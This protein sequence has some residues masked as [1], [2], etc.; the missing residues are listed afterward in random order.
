MRSAHRE[1]LGS[2]EVKDNINHIERKASM[3][4]KAVWNIITN[5]FIAI[6]NFPRN[7]YWHLGIYHNLLAN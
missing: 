4:H 7:V 1:F 5:I 6:Q 2:L 3:E